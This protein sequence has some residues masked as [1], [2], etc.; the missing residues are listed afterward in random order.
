M[1]IHNTGPLFCICVEDITLKSST[2][3]K[4][5]FQRAFGLRSETEPERYKFQLFELTEYSIQG[6]ISK[7]RT[8]VIFGHEIDS[9]HKLW[10]VDRLVDLEKVV[11]KKFRTSNEVLPS[12]VREGLC[13]VMNLEGS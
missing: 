8:C 12:F 6:E 9:V 7:C 4:I 13:A 10:E 2:E 5:S 11:R 1:G 3:P